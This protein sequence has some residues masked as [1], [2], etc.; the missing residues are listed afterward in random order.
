[1]VCGEEAGGVPRPIV[2]SAG[3]G[4]GVTRPIVV[5]AGGLGVTSVC[6]NVV[7]ILVLDFGPNVG[8]RG[9]KWSLVKALTPVFRF[10]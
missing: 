10:D 9:C 7:R 5:S 3:G 6:K 8:G 2:V 1:M 4:V